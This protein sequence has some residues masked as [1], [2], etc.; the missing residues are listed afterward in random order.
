MKKSNPK[1]LSRGGVCGSAVYYFRDQNSGTGIRKQT[2]QQEVVL[3]TPPPD[4]FD[5]SWYL[6]TNLPLLCT[7]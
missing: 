1:L 4:L 6:L 2:K 7:Y 5:V 3:V